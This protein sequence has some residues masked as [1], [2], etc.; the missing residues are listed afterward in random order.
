MSEKFES[1]RSAVFEKSP[2]ARCN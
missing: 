1:D 2:E